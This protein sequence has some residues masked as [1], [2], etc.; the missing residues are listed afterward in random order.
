MEKQVPSMDMTARK[1]RGHIFSR[2]KSYPDTLV[3]DDL[4]CTNPNCPCQEVSFTAYAAKDTGRKKPLFSFRLNTEAW[5][6]SDIE[7]YGERQGYKEIIA[8]FVTHLPDEMK[9][10]LRD[11]VRQAKKD[12]DQNYLENI[13]RKILE[14]IRQ[15]IMVPYYNIFGSTPGDMEMRVQLD[16]KEYFIVDQYCMS[17]GG[18]PISLT[19][20]ELGAGGGKAVLHVSTRP[21]MRDYQVAQA[22]AP[23]LSADRVMEQLRRRQP[24][25]RLLRK[26]Q[27]RMQEAARNIKARY[28]QAAPPSSAARPAAA[29][30]NDPCP[31]GSGKK[32]KRCCG[33]VR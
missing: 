1:G 4:Y 30:R 10:I 29:G 26:R 28:F 24:L 8:S 19:F 27:A 14:D 17:C 20:Y 21:E 15:G 6:A 9:K 25:R 16:G 3:F 5:Q 13:D 32:Y 12:G 22:P 33:A 23:Q 31:C 7:N 2:S 18:C 11:N